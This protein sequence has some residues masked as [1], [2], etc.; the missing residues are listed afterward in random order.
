[1][2]FH[3]VSLT[4]IFIIMPVN[5]LF[6]HK[7]THMWQKSAPIVHSKNVFKKQTVFRIRVCIFPYPEIICSILQLISDKIFGII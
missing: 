7:I 3:A 6:L 5:P 1:M 4:V 2:Q